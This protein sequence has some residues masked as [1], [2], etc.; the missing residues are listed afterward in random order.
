[1]KLAGP[2]GAQ[3]AEW[4]EISEAARVVSYNTVADLKMANGRVY[5]ATWKYHGR[6]CAWWPEPG[7]SRRSLIA[8]YEPVAIQVVAPGIGA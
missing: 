2:F 3:M 6:C 4:I 7:Q 5:R 8:L 1:M